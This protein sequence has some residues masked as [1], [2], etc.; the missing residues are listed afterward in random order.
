MWEESQKRRVWRPP[1]RG[2]RLRL[3][4]VS[5]INRVNDVAS[6]RVD[7][8][9]LPVLLLT[10][11]DGITADGSLLIVKVQEQCYLPLNK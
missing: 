7:P 4:G 11:M 8:L 1:S 6:T 9:L 3:A 2:G 5:V 10:V